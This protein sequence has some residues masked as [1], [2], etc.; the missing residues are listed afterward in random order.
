M[1][2]KTKEVLIKIAEEVKQ[3]AKEYFLKKYAAARNIEQYL[4]IKELERDSKSGL[5]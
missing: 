1:D 2:K 4:V 5:I 3:T